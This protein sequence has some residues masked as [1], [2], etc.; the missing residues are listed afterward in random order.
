MVH[1]EVEPG[2]V[3]GLLGLVMVEFLCCHKVFHVFVV[4]P[5]FKL[6]VGTFQK[7]API[8]QSL[9]DHQHFLVMDLVVLLYCTE[10]F[11]VVSY[12]MPLVVLWRLL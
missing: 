1:G 8:L 10:T 4:H 12:R 5:D 6:V 9:D 2:Q 11:G 3:E 7:M